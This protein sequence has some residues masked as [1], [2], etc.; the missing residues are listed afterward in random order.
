MEYVVD[1]WV[2]GKPLE[3]R[4]VTKPHLWTVVPK[5]VAFTYVKPEECRREM[6]ELIRKGEVVNPLFYQRDK[7]F[8][9]KMKLMKNQMGHFV[10][11]KKYL[12]K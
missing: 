7:G 5:K 8:V 4:M 1:D 6:R 9:R 10:K 12:G 3:F 2:Y 11:F